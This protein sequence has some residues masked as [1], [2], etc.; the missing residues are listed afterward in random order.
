MAAASFISLFGG[1]EASRFQSRVLTDQSC[2]GAPGKRWGRPYLLNLLCALLTALGATALTLGAV[3]EVWAQPEQTWVFTVSLSF[4]VN[5][6]P[7]PVPPA[8]ADV[9]KDISATVSSTGSFSIS[10]NGVACPPGVLGTA[11]STAQGTIGTTLTVS[12]TVV[13]CGVSGSFTGSAGLDR[14]FPNATTTIGLGTLTGSGTVPPPSPGLPSQDAVVSGTFTARCS[15]N[16][17]SQQ[18]QIA[19]ATAAAQQAATLGNVAVLTTS[20]QNTN[21]GLRLAALRGGATGVGLSG[22]SLKIDGE[23]VPLAAASGLLASLGGGASADQSPLGRL[24]I[25]ATGQGSFGD[26]DVTS[27]EPGFD[28][29]TGGITVGADYRIT[30][31][32]VLGGAFG[33]LRTKIDLDSSAG[34]SAI[35]GYSLSGYASYYIEKLYLDGIAT[36][37]WNNYNNER[38]IAGVNATAR[39]STSGTQFAGSVNIGYNFNVAGLTFGPTGRVNYIHVNIDGYQESG[40]DGFNTRIGDQTIDSLTTDLGGQVMYAISTRWGVLMPLLR[41]EWEHEFLANSRTVTA[42]VVN[43]PNTAVSVLTNSPDRNYF[44]LGVGLTATFK[45]G[46]SAFGY[47]EAVL[48]RANFTGHLFNAG[49]RFEF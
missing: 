44:N 35:N 43:D 7:V 36:V 18:Q 2:R 15:I 48:G 10:R 1:E 41:F 42:S 40:A 46:I 47:Y 29:H 27:R 30:D 19:N 38:N 34:D 5:G 37:G 28:F 25:F 23:P 12:G 39:S 9:L 4:T 16:C 3:S 6:M 17:I 21:I 11:S 31:Q 45:R 14:P 13:G 22:L 20:V 24:G 26:Q 8:V 49:V 33:Y 32:V